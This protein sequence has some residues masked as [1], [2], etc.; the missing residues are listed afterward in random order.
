MRAD[1]SPTALRKTRGPMCD[2]AARARTAIHSEYERRLALRRASAE[3]MRR[4]AARLS[5]ARL[6]VFAAGVALAGLAFAAQRVSAAWLW[7][8]MLGFASL[9]VWHD[10]VLRRQAEAER[11]V[12]WYD[13]GMARLEA[14]FAGRG[15]AG[16]RFR[17]AR[18][19]YAEDLDLFGKGGLFELLCRARTTAGEETLAAWLLAPADPEPVRARQA[20]VVELA[21]RHDLREELA[22]LGDEVSTGLHAEALARWGETAP[23]PPSRGLRLAAA[24][25]ATAS[26]ASFGAFLLGAPIIPWLAVLAAELLLAARLRRRVRATLRAIDEPARD[27][28]LLARLLAVF[29]RERFDAA[30]LG[31]LQATLAPAGTGDGA[32]RCASRQIAHLERLSQ[33]LDARR[34]QLFAP[35]GAALLFTTQ[36]ALAIDAWRARCGPSLRAWIASVGEFEALASLATHAAENPDDAFPELC[37]GATRFEA[38]GI[39]HPLLP[40]ARCVRNDVSLGELQLLV[41]SGSNMSG[42]S[43]LLRTVGSQVVLAQA[44]APVR[45][46]RLRMTPLAVGA[47][48]RVLDSLQEGASRFYAE[49]Q[50]L[51][52]IVELASG[53]RHPPVIF[54]LDEILHGTNSHDR[55]IGAEAVVRGLLARGAIG[56]VTT[57]DLALARIAEVL[58]PRA[59]NV[60]FEDELV[61]G[62]IHFDYR[63]R[64]GVVQRS[65]ALA[66]M[67]AV[68]LEV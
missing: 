52:H 5:N 8:P 27:L 51:H 25:L 10:R 53:G 36:V 2:P 47:S 62:R 39:G 60:H 14:R 55:R 37:S 59:A 30:R 66:L 24:A 12:R 15:A 64:P 65:N 20:A 3:A 7:V 45:A 44:G 43:T 28:E 42:K 23:P 16:E 17:D 33:L 11:A 48:I 9:V 6:A 18:H 54:L 68:G 57:H 29:E 49:I 1:A 4:L 61:A 26:V 46:R 34:N 58:A 22:L 56:L 38:Q 13:D 32:G 35:V 19:P 21:P 67:R 41:V 40:E 31:E 50:R 63:M